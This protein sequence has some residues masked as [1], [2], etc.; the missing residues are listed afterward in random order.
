MSLTNTTTAALNLT[1]VIIAAVVGSL[2][3]TCCFV[4]IF[5]FL[6]RRRRTREA[7]TTK[8]L[9][10][11]KLSFLPI[12]RAL[13]EKADADVILGYLSSSMVQSESA[14]DRDYDGR[15]AF[16]IAV[17]NDVDMR[18]VS[19]LLINSLPFD[20]E[21]A[22]PLSPSRHGFA[23][24]KVVELGENSMHYWKFSWV[25][26]GGYGGN[27][28]MINTVTK[29]GFEF[30]FVKTVFL[31][32]HSHHF[33]S[34]HFR[35]NWKYVLPSSPCSSSFRCS[36]SPPHFLSPS[37]STSSSFPFSFRFPNPYK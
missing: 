36:S 7:R 28:H 20:C 14:K 35:P 9:R 37:P 34:H 19:A 29:N 18:V 15:T 33:G 4:C 31:Y 27:H 30:P 3:V 1:V 2:S 24:A 5:A 22:E 16:D 13:I 10:L 21:S 11:L 6:I 8:K 23:W 26:N 12:H 25:E 32:G 17:D